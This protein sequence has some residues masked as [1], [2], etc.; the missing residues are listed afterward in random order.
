M[1]DALMVRNLDSLGRIVIPIGIRR[2]FGINTD[3]PMEFFTREDSIIIYRIG[4]E[5][6][7]LCGGTKQF[8][9]HKQKYV[10]IRCVNGLK[11]NPIPEI[12][13]PSTPEDIQNLSDAQMVKLFLD[14]MK[15]YPG[16]SMK[17]YAKSLK[18]SPIYVK[19]LKNK[20]EE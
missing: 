2:R 17:T 15:Q 14:L 16:A 11:G 19:F 4:N 20:S 3:T 7:L 13:L 12:Q 6:C 1:S 8:I 10:C 9:Q 18:I 5:S